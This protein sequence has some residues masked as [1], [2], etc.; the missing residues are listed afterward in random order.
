M[1]A[2]TNRIGFDV[3]AAPLAEIDRRGL[4]QAWYSALHLARDARP[5]AAAS[6]ETVRRS[7]SMPKVAMLRAPEGVAKKACAQVVALH[8]PAARGSAAEAVD[9]R[10]ARLPLAK[11]IERALMRP[12]TPARTSAFVVDGPLRVHVAIHACGNR[13]NLV[14]V[15]APQARERVARALEQARYALA[16]R[17]LVV[18][19]SL[20]ERVR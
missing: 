2:Y 1:D 18:D 15:C 5:Q 12:R 13:V 11:K 10:S 19:A 6:E 20:R 8:A 17:G 4:S 7:R 3:L 16:G 9:R 14:A